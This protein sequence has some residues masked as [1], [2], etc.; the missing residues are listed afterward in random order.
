GGESL[1]SSSPLFSPFSLTF[2]SFFCFSCRLSSCSASFCC[3]AVLSSV[4]FVFNWFMRRKVPIPK[5]NPMHAITSILFFMSITPMLIY[6]M[7]IS[8][9][10]CPMYYHVHFCS[11]IYWMVVR[12]NYQL[13]IYP[14]LT[15]SK[16]SFQDFEGKQRGLVKM[17]K[18]YTSLCACINFRI[19][20]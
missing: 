2:F 3:V 6:Y 12:K 18:P 5:S 11:N 9:T 16:T 20:L 14:P 1:S 17:K 4:L 8:Q 13:T 15:G 7:Y 19:L 10:C